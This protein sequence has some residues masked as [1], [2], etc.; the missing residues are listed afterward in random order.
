VRVVVADTSPLHY[1]ILT[2][3][4]D[5]LPRLFQQVIAPELVRAELLDDEAPTLVRTWAMAPPAWFGVRPAPLDPG[6]DLIRLD[7]GERALTLS[8][9]LL[10]IVIE[11]ELP[12]L[13][14]P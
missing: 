14:G 12:A 1:L 5:L 10:K 8:L 2:S 9:P 3:A 6:E 13:G 11:Q 4:I 7:A